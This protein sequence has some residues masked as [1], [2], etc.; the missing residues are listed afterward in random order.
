MWS[1]K[2]RAWGLANYPGGDTS[3]PRATRRPPWESGRQ[4]EFEMGGDFIALAN[5]VRHGAP[6]AA[7][8]PGAERVGTVFTYNY[9]KNYNN[10]DNKKTAI[11]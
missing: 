1:S 10:N 6:R 7:F 3:P 2:S 11:N 9:Y 4:G 8:L 5:T